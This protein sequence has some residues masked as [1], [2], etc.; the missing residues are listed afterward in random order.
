M[1]KFSR[2]FSMLL[3]VLAVGCVVI[4]DT[5]D[6]NINV[7]IRHIQEQADEIWDDIEGDTSSSAVWDEI[8]G[9]TS[10]SA[11]NSSVNDVSYFRRAVQ[12]LSPIQI[13]YAAEGDG[14]SPRLDQIKAKIKQRYGDV[15]AAKRTGAVGETNRGLLELAQ[16]EK[17]SDSE[18]KNK[19]QRIIAA[20]N[21]DRKAMYKEI[22]RLNKDDNLTVTAVEH[23]HAASLMKRAKKGDL[24]QAPPAGEHFDN[25]RSTPIGKKLGGA[26][27]P[28]AWVTLP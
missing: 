21:Q 2:I 8:E 10:S 24:V 18:Q 15:Q 3:V 20:E 14:T 23:V 4:P 25:F 26:A 9:D 13:A 7:T 1:N 5:F 16:P 6:A 11:V 17:I 12:F 28:G 22:A 19:V 27:K